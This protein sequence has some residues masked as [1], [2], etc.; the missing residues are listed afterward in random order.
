MSERTAALRTCEGHSGP[1][2]DA[3]AEVEAEAEADDDGGQEGKKYFLLDKNR[4]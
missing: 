4:L 2:L 1:P 3:S